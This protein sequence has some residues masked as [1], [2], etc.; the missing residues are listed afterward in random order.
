LQ[1]E[2]GTNVNQWHW[3]EKDCMAWSKN[4]LGELFSGLTLV[5]GPAKVHTTGLESVTGEGALLVA[6]TAFLGVGRVLCLATMAADRRQQWDKT[7]GHTS[8]ARVTSQG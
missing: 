7:L 1:R 5:E 6:L 4:H 8:S 2:D 3:K